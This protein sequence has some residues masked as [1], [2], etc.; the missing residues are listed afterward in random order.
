MQT[1]DN[2]DYFNRYHVPSTKFLQS[3]LNENNWIYPNF[4][5]RCGTMQKIILI[6]NYKGKFGIIAPYSKDF[7]KSL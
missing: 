1:G 4:W 5:I 2:L 6:Q 7:C 3:Y